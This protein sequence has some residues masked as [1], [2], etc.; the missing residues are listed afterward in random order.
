M[1]IYDDA[2]QVIVESMWMSLWFNLVMQIEFKANE[3]LNQGVN[4][5]LSVK[6]LLI[7]FSK[8]LTPCFKLKK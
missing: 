6:L 2:C 4:F 3:D 5:K 1:T 7:A 8:E